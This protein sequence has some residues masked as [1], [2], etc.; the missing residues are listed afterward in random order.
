M[1]IVRAISTDDF[2]R[3]RALIEA[4]AASLGID[5]EFQDF[6]REVAHLSVEYGPPEGGLLLAEDAGNPLGCVGVRKIADGVCEMKRLYVAPAAR[7]RGVG[8]ALADAIIAEARRLGYERMRL[9]T[10]ASMREARQLY[11]SLGFREIAPYRYNPVDGT[12]F[13][14][15]RLDEEEMTNPTRDA[16]S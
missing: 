8:R 2:A 6:S 4:Y 3:A 14:E 12:S 16:D 13:M 15:L 9:D 1:R 11:A 10:L 5:L 7:G